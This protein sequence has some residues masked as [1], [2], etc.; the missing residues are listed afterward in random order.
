M[1]WNLRV[2]RV[3]RSALRNKHSG[4]NL[5]SHAF[6]LRINSALA[7]AIR[8]SFADSCPHVDLRT[9]TTNHRLGHGNDNGRYVEARE[10]IHTACAIAAHS[11][12]AK[13]R[14][15]DCPEDILSTV[16]DAEELS[17]VEYEGIVPH[18]YEP[19]HS[20]WTSKYGAERSLSRRGRVKQN[21]AC[22]GYRRRGRPENADGLSLTRDIDHY[23]D[24]HILARVT[25]IVDLEL[26]EQIWRKRVAR[27]LSRNAERIHI[28]DHHYP[29]SI[30]R[31]GE[32]INVRYVAFRDRVHNRGLAMVSRV[33]RGNSPRDR[34]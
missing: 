20:G 19:L 31:I 17:H 33:C 25:G 12:S 28:H 27:E 3:P 22:A 34:A 24:D 14:T 11:A 15:W 4:E 30:V 18:A 9:R 32:K 29:S 7:A 13:T 2:L 8:N 16:E 6:E 10:A 5:L 26:V 23:L 21:V 1:F